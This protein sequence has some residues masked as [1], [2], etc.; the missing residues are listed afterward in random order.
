MLLIMAVVSISF[1]GSISTKSP[2]ATG[3]VLVISSSF[4]TPFILAFQ[5]LPDSSLTMYQLPVDLYTVPFI[6]ANFLNQYEI[7]CG[8]QGYLLN[9]VNFNITS[10]RSKPK[11]TS[12][13][14]RN[15]SSYR[16]YCVIS[17]GDVSS[18]LIWS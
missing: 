16:L 14:G 11:A 8:C 9:T 12:K 15:F 4:I 17:M 13:K 2:T 18:S 6:A 1:S 3:L 7:H 10:R 5:N